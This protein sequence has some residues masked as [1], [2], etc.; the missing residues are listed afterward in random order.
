MRRLLKDSRLRAAS[1]FTLIELLL[2]NV[3]IGILSGVLIAVINPVQTRRRANESVLRSNLD[4]IC[5]AMQA[6][7]AARSDPLTSCY[8]SDFGTFA[9]LIGVNTPTSPTGATWTT[10]RSR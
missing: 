2:V 5:L 10:T 1:G 9:S 7:A 4:K 8:N 3:I 6:C